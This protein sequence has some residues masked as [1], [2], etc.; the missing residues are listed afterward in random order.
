MPTLADGAR[1]VAAVLAQEARAAL[2]RSGL[3]AVI[4]ERGRS[5]SRTIVA[6]AFILARRLRPR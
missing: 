2:E 6:A 3:A 5:L 1:E 4:A